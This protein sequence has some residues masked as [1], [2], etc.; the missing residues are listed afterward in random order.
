MRNRRFFL[1]N[2]QLILLSF[3]GAILAGSLL[4]SLPVSMADGR[5]ISFTDAFFTATTAVCVTGLVTVPVTAFSPL[6]QAV[7]L[8]LMQIGGLGVITVMSAFT[9]AFHRKV[10]LGDRL[11]LQDAFNL[12]GISGVVKFIRRAVVGTF[13]LE[14]AGALFVMTAF[15]PRYGVRGI[16]Y[17]VFHAV[18]AF[19]NAGLD[20]LGTNSL[21]EWADSPLVCGVTE[22]LII[23]GGIG[24][25]SGGTWRGSPGSGGNCGI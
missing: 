22:C 1:S 17:A 15:V 21:C 2:T 12:N 14:G 23:L 7:I 24:S 11:L 20:V 9:L 4:L 5:A 13:A 18:S 25:W 16:W 10:G 6:G 19:C 3:L 8:V